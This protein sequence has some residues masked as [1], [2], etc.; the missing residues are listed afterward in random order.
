VEDF[1]GFAQH[2]KEARASTGCRTA[3]QDLKYS[4]YMDVNSHT[5]FVLMS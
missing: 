4:K 5:G 3:A 2:T 1:A